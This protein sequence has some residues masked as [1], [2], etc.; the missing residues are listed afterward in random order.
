MRKLAP[1]LPILIL[2]VTLGCFGSGDDPVTPDP[3]LTA[4]QADSLAGFWFGAMTVDLGAVE[5][6]EDLQDLDLD[7][8]R[9]GFQA[10]LDDYPNHGLANLGMATVKTVEV[11]ADPTLWNALDSLFTEINADRAPRARSAVG[12]PLVQQFRLITEAPLL[13]T[14]LNRDFP[15]S[16]TAPALQRFIHQA[17]IPKVTDILDHIQAAENDTDFSYEFTIDEDSY[18]V[19]LGEIYLLD[20]VVQGLRAG[21]RMTLPYDLDIEHP[22]LG[23]DWLLMLGDDEQFDYQLVEVPDDGDSLFVQHRST[24]QSAVLAMEMLEFQLAPGSDF[25]TLREISDGAPYEGATQLG[26]AHDDLL[27]MLGAL[28]DGVAFILAEQDDQTDDVVPIDLLELINASIAECADCPGEW[29]DIQSVIDWLELL[30]TEPM[31]IPL[32]FG[33]RAPSFITIDI[34]AFFEGGVPDWKDVLPYHSWRPQATWITTDEW[35]Y[36]WSPWSGEAWIWDNE[37]QEPIIFY[38]IDYVEE[39]YYNEYLNQPLDLRDGEGGDIIDP[40][41]EMPY[42]PD[43]SFG[44]IFPD[45]DRPDWELLLGYGPTGD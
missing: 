29:E 32:D 23:Y 18:E 36:P 27:G 13:M 22:T 11:G 45:M 1:F 3:D 9:A 10:V 15:A 35:T 31:D 7:A 44:G 37:N 40:E 4:A 28:E 42:F 16:L 21:L 6:P 24:A 14:S 25:L 34:A 8:H 33:D 26:L 19:D 20:A 12:Q 30:L 41:M 17:M 39:Y 43:Y 5:D 2:S 38:G